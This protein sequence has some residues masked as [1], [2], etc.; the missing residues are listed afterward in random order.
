MPYVGDEM[1]AALRELY[2]RDRA[3][4]HE[5]LEHMV[6]KV[7]E[8]GGVR[9]TATVLDGRP[10]GAICE[11]AAATGA[12]LIVMTTHG[13]AGLS[14]A[15]LGS[16]A[17]AVVRHAGVPVLLLRSSA[18]ADARPPASF[19]RVLIPLDGSPQA[20]SILPHAR[21]LGSLFGAQYSLMTVVTPLALPPQLGINPVP[22]P[23]VEDTAM[24]MRVARA[25]HRIRETAVRLR[26][27]H[28]DME[29]ATTV[30]VDERVAHAIL[31][32]AERERADVIALTTFGHGPVRLLFGSVADKVIR[33][34]STA[35][36]LFRPAHD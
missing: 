3:E 25:D 1:L 6:A 2:L 12:D 34:A 29:V 33:G 19:E 24:A 10:A 8:G 20:Q 22:T 18:A 15:W 36:L 14:R 32:Q 4:S 7:S 35:V 13:R 9:P 27:E 23:V 21:A 31:E 11:H 30:V 17:D 28:E 5:Y 26:S 16:V